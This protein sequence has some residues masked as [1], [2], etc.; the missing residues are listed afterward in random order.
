[1]FII[2]TT[3]HDVTAPVL[4]QVTAIPSPTNDTTPSYTFSSSE[5]GT[6]TYG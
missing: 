4:A 2:D 3:I 6:T 1:L 5:A